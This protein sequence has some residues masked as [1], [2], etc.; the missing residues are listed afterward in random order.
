MRARPRARPGPRQGQEPARGH[1]SQG[2][3]LRG[4]A[5]AKDEAPERISDSQDNLLVS[6]PSKARFGETAA[7]TCET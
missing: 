2:R 6:G 5:D 4:Q 3:R 7:E 1:P